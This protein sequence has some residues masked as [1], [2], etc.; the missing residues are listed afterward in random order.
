M[1]GPVTGARH[2]EAHP[3]RR[4]ARAAFGVNTITVTATAATITAAP[5]AITGS[6]V[7]TPTAHHCLSP[8]RTQAP[9][10]DASHQST[11]NTPPVSPVNVPLPTVGQGRQ[12]RHGLPCLRS[13]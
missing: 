9:V 12:T 4:P 6:A 10:P 5:S 3:P 8:R 7:N 11:P 2:T 13:Q 1:V